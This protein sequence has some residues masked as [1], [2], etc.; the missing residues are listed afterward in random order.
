MA[1]IQQKLEQFQQFLQ[2]DSELLSIPQ[3]VH[4]HLW[5]QPNF[6]GVVFACG[7]SGV[8][9]AAFFEKLAHFLA[10]AAKVGVV[11]AEP[12]QFKKNGMAFLRVVDERTNVASSCEIDRETALQTSQNEETD[13]NPFTLTYYQQNLAVL[14]FILINFSAM[15]NL[16][17]RAFLR[18]GEDGREKCQYG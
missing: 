12:S 7:Y 9:V 13:T 6:L 14:N 4:R 5:T 1:R 15:I 3:R 10:F 8:W 17:P 16:V 11:T 2:R 18:R